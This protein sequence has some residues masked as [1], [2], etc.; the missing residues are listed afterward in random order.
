MSISCGIFDSMIDMIDT[1]YQYT[2]LQFFENPQF[3]EETNQQTYEM[4]EISNEDLNEIIIVKFRED[5]VFSKTNDDIDYTPCDY[6]YKNVKIILEKWFD[7]SIRNDSNVSEESL[8]SKYSYNPKYSLMLAI[9][10]LSCERKKPHDPEFFQKNLSSI[11][12]RYINRELVP[13]HYSITKNN[14]I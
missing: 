10:K 11:R 12:F 13:Y 6:D 1:V 14:C 8:A 7:V 9:S 4:V 2:G 5:L 3:D